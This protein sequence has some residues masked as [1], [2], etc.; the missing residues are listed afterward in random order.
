MPYVWG[1]FPVARGLL[2]AVAGK[3]SFKA[4]LR[5][6]VRNVRMPLPTSKRPILPWA[7]F[8][9]K[10]PYLSPLVSMRN[11]FPKKGTDLY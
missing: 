2:D 6:R 1:G 9:F 4:L 8:P 11:L 10:V 7:L 5:Q 3:L